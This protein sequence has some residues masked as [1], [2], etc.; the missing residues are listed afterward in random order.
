VLEVQLELET[1]LETGVGV[2]PGK[3]GAGTTVVSSISWVLIY[4]VPECRGMGTRVIIVRTVVMF[5]HGVGL[6]DGCEDWLVAVT[7]AHEDHDELVRCQGG[8][9][10]FEEEVTES[11]AEDKPVMRVRVRVLVC[12]AVERTVVVVVGSGVSVSSGPWGVSL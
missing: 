8:R 6:K 12:V 10:C 5:G 1:S 3:K 11:E 4:G 7:F 2:Q 9:K